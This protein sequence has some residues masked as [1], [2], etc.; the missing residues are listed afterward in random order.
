MPPTGTASLANSSILSADPAIW[1]LPYGDD[2]LRYLARLLLERHREQLPDLSHQIVLFPHAGAAA[3]FRLIL[4]AQARAAGLAAL[5]PPVIDTLAAWAR[6]RAGGEGQPLNETSREILLRGLLDEL[7]VWSRQYDTWSLVGSLLALF[8]EL[9]LQR[10]RLP[11]EPAALLRRIGQLSAAGL[12]EG[13]PFVDE[14]RLVHTLWAAWRAHLARHRWQDAAQELDAGLRRGLEDLPADTRLYLAGFVD[15]TRAEREWLM[16]QM[17]QGRLTLVLQGH[18]AADDPAAGLW[19]NL[20]DIAGVAPRDAYG[21]FLDRAFARGGARLPQRAREQREAAAVSPARARL[22]IHEAADA[23]S[24]ARAIDLQVRR[25]RLQG[26]RDIGIVTADRRL[27]RRVRALL[28]RARIVLLDAAGWALSTTSAATALARWLECLEQNFAHAPLLDLLKSPFLQP[29]G[30]RTELGRLLP[31]FER[32]VVREYNIAAGLD[33]YRHGLSRARAEAKVGTDTGAA[34]FLEQLLES[35][36]AAAAALRALRREHRVPALDF[37][38]A[39]QESLVRLGLHAG[40]EADAAGCELLAVLEEMRLAA[41]HA[42][43]RLSWDEFHQWL[44]RQMEQRRFHPPMPGHGVEL[45]GF[46]ESRL[47]H[48][49]ALI[50]AGCLREYLP[51]DIGAPPYFNDDIRTELGLP[52]LARRYA[53]K[54]HDFRRLLEAA[55]RVMIS[56]RAERDG[57]PLSPS[58]WVERLRTFHALAYGESLADPALAWLVQ[59]PQTMIAAREITLPPPVQPPAPRL[60]PALVPAVFTATDHQ[61]LIDCPYQFFAACGLGLAAAKEIEEEID[62]ADFGQYVHR[63][64]QAFHAGVR[65][66][67][68]PWRQPLDD[69]TL[70]Q[71]HALLN[72]ISQAIFAADLRRHFVARAWLYR[73]QQCIPAYLAWERVRAADWQVQATE[74]KVQRELC[75]GDTCV[76][77]AGRLDRVDRGSGGIALIDYKTGG[78]PSRDLVMRGENIQLPFYALLLDEKNIAQA[79]FLS[80]QPGDVA[81]KVA[82]DAETLARLRTA[83]RQRLLLLKR[84]LEEAVPLPAWGDAETCAVCAMEGLCRRQLWA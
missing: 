9:T 59:Q 52:S 4:L 12:Q 23:E 54:F 63:I 34:V 8:D 72:E 19:R 81:E 65:G 29:G 1:L 26:L 57:E 14:A 15:F 36:D 51:G 46:A 7:P 3:R 69:A 62:K 20:G 13:S 42:Q 60:P 22:T 31:W 35:I 77:I 66:L 38:A 71:A 45:M 64:L 76:A 82:L 11:E 78:Y 74:L 83:L 43:P 56:L 79:V 55:P 80:L 41:M 75:E 48:G 32:Y 27:A 68:G 30:Q 49:E 2:P 58:P 33:N 28:E 73:W 37:L 17:A 84:Q 16:M 50:I 25:W 18:A 70:P 44:R 24:E 40:F 53:G 21:A 39:L 6:R 61:R 67:P 47:Y 5:L 10:C